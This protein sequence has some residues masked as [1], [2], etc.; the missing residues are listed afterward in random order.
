MDLDANSL[1]A[2]M[3][4]SGIGFVFL[5]YGR[6]QS[7]LPQMVTGLILMIFPYFVSNVALMG[8]IATG[9]IL[10]AWLAIRAGA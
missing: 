2:S 8:G 9:V 1:L 6:K 3:V 5:S 7:R 10:L 4:V